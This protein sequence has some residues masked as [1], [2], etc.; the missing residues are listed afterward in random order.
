MA[1]HQHSVILP[2]S[3]LQSSREVWAWLQRHLCF[4]RVCTEHVCSNTKYTGNMQH[5]AYVGMLQHNTELQL[6]LGMVCLNLL[7]PQLLAT[8]HPPVST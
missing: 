2:S 1:W 8:G 3:K 6:L 4:Y 7:L 5:C